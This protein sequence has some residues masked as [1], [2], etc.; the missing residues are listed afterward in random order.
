MSVLSLSTTATV[1]DRTKAPADYGSLI[2][3]GFIGLVLICLTA[4]SIYFLQQP[5]SVETLNSITNAI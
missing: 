1:P 5:V 3:L 4:G 2:A